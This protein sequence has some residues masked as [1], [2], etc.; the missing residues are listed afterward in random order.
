MGR[1]TRVK[2]VNFGNL[3]AVKRGMP[4]PLADLYYSSLELSWPAF[5]AIVAT[6]FL[7]VNL[8]FGLVYVAL[9][10]S[11]ANAAPGSF[12]DG[13]FFSVETLATVGYGNMAPIR[14]EAHA[15]ATL[16]IFIGLLLTA[17]LTGLTFARFARPRESL[18]FSKVAVVGDLDGREAL[19]V[20]IVSLRSQPIADAQASMS[21]VESL[22]FVDGRNYRQ[23]RDLPLVR[24]H[25][26]ML[27]LSWTIVHV[28]EPDSRIRDAIRGGE[29][30][31]LMVTV[32][33]TDTLLASPTFGGRFYVPHEIMIDHDFVDIINETDEGVI[34]VD[35]TKFHETT[36]RSVA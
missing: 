27:S 22:Q 10:G 29:K 26:P 11:I 15:V 23:V 9:P 16:E 1:R 4:S 12:L 13:F 30:V 35:I 28:F 25:N 32:G 8:L 31:R 18:L 2:A 17:T 20:R 6:V 19:M 5:I 3:P 21:F 36:P 33:G 7:S 14:Y 34:E 24:S